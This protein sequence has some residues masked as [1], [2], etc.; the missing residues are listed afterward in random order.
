MLKI[1]RILAVVLTTLSL[2]GVI[3]SQGVESAANS[4]LTGVALPA[5][6]QRVGAASV[7]A[8]ISGTLEKIVASADGKLRQGDS[9]V[10]A[11]GG[12]GY[13]K[14]NA[15]NIV[16]KLRGSLESAGWKY[17]VGGTADGVTLFRALKD[18]RAPRAVVGFYA[19]TNDAMLVAWTEILAADA[20]QNSIEIDSQTERIQS[21]AGKS[22][23]GSLQEIVGKWHN[24]NVSMMGEKNL[25]TGRITSSNG[26]TVSYKFFADGRFEYVGYIKS[27]MYGCTT[28]LFNDK[29]GKV[30]ISGNQIT[31]VPTKNYWKNTYSCSPASNKER[32]YVLER[33]TYT[34]RT[35][36]DE[37]G[38]TL[39]CLANAKGE[40]CFRR[41]E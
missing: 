7:P 33:E 38:K 25:T 32:D 8:E 14:S 15:P 36:T 17:E 23:N 3:W 37:Y 2:S 1:N 30:E 9:E 16:G 12:T 19:A 39:I 20:A 5:N 13:R 22:S 40:S 31:L 18:G 21:A 26:T 35:K 24:G 34:Y 41:E 28:D 11:W 6:A 4:N 27:T 29:R 10:L